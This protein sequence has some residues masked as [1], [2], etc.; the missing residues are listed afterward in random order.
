[1]ASNSMALDRIPTKTLDCCNSICSIERDASKKFLWDKTK[2]LA[3]NMNRRNIFVNTIVM[4]FSLK[5]RM[6]IEMFPY[7][8]KQN[9]NNII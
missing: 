9:K 3:F 4:I 7:L 5:K 6:L 8:V 2:W 1:M